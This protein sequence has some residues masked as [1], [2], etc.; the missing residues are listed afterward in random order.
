MLDPDNAPVGVDP[1]RSS[2]ARVYDHL[3]GGNHAYAIDITVAAQI[4][5][6]MPEVADVA[7]ENRS[8]LSRA[9]RFISRET[10][11]R[12]FLDLGS[13]LPT[14][15]NVHQ[16]VQRLHQD[17]KVAYVDYDPVVAAHGKAILQENGDT[18]FVL[19]DIFD[20]QSILENPDVRDLLDWEQPIALLAVA[21]LHHHNGE[22][23][24]PAEVMGQFIDRL[25]AGSFVVISHV[26]DPSDGSED[27]E[28]LQ[29]T[30]DVIHRGSM[31]D[32]T[33]RTKEEIRELFHG[34]ELV[35]ANGETEADIVP[36]ADWWPDGPRYRPPTIAQRIIAGG[37]AIKR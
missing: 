5:A 14:A 30:L 3:L 34:L 35:P 11:V 26:I 36:V 9:C 7:L 10:D 29:K 17:A 27:D 15:E 18:R 4:S 1:T 6:A 33:A 25:P 20:P 16:V 22:R 31:R 23:G 19:A 8:F 2:V 28:I 32:I 12:Q 21:A 13:G 37:V 24:K